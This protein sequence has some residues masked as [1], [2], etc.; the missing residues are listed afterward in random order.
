MSVPT[1]GSK[2][3]PHVW[4]ACLGSLPSILI[5][6]LYGL[7]PVNR[8]IISYNSFQFLCK[9]GRTTGKTCNKE[10]WTLAALGGTQRWK[11][12]SNG[13]RRANAATRGELRQSVRDTL[14]GTLKEWRQ[15]ETVK[16]EG[17]NSWMM[18]KTKWIVPQ[19]RTWVGWRPL[20]HSRMVLLARWDRNCKANMLL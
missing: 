13:F 7:I 4:P 5:L 17:D 18:M 11:V 6:F 8:H 1:T 9:V 15:W 16:L 3:W 2:N 19:N 12:A 20:L 14:L 10:G